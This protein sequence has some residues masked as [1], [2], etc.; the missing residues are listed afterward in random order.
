MQQTSSADDV[1]DGEG[2]E[3]AR[4]LVVRAIDG[5]WI[6][7]EDVVLPVTGDETIVEIQQ[8]GVLDLLICSGTRLNPVDMTF[9]F[10]TPNVCSFG[11][12]D[13][14]DGACIQSGVKCLFCFR[15]VICSW[16][17]GETAP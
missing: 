16:R 12:G 2:E 3:E 8:V 17:Y 9:P 5:D 15:G 1:S 4:T 7:G 11:R 13:I 14:L 10:P 6:M